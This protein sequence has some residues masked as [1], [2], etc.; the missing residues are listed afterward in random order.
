MIVAS[1]EAHSCRYCAL[2]WYINIYKTI[3]QDNPGY[4]PMP[5]PIP[6]CEK[7]T[8]TCIR[9]MPVSSIPKNSAPTA[10]TLLVKIEALISNIG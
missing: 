6:L 3:V 1:N 10:T 2:E 4:F 7:K 5:E 9:L 8:Y